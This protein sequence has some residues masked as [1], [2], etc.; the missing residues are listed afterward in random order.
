MM[1]FVGQGRVLEEGRHELI[2]ELQLTL[3]AA[4]GRLVEGLQCRVG[5]Q[6][7]R[8]VEGEEDG[9]F[10]APLDELQ[11]TQGARGARGLTGERCVNTMKDVVWGGEW[12]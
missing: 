9:E 7:A 2:Q 12:G 8:A 4:E 6:A 3:V 5:S 10:E 11:R 1:K